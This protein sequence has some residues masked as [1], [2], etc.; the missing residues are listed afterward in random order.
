MGSKM[1]RTEWLAPKER[2]GQL[3][4]RAGHDEA[5]TMGDFVFRSL[6]EYY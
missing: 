1:A 4:E 6:Q 2:D 5:L 3:Y